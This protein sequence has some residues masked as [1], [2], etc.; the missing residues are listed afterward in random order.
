[1]LKKDHQ[2]F[3]KCPQSQIQ[4]KHYITFTKKKVI[5]IYKFKKE[6]TTKIIFNNYLLY[7]LYTI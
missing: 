5:N 4:S 6:K 1:M 2:L 3:I 7:K